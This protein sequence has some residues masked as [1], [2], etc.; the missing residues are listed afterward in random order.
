MIEEQPAVVEENL[1]NT[2]PE[3]SAKLAGLYYVSDEEPGF[4]RKRRGRGFT[5]IDPGGRCVNDP[6]LRARF[7]ALVIPPAWTDVWICAD[8]NGHIQVTGRDDQGRKQYIYHP[9][10]GE[11]RN[12][13]KF[14]RL[15]P[16]GEA[17]PAIRANV[18]EDLRKHSLSRQKVVA[19]VIRLL[20]E[21]LI[22]IGN[23]EYA[24]NNE[25]YGL[26]TLRDDHIQVSGSKII[27]V[28]K[29]KSG[30][31]HEVDL[32]SKRLAELVKQ[33]QELP[34]QELFQYLDEAGAYH[35]INSQD[36]NDYLR[37]ITGQDFTAKDFRTWGG[38]VLAAAEL[39]QQGPVE[40]E[41]ANKKVIVQAVKA[42]AE[43]LGNTP[44]ICRDYYIHPAIIDAYLNRSLFTAME[45]AAQEV[46]SNE[47]TYD[48]STEE[49]AVMI[50]SRQALAELA[51]LVRGKNNH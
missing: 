16:F 43:A 46:T 10:W 35:P 38:T 8:P 41:T 42:V 39:Y 22:R 20:E 47:A 26:T 50:L 9:R 7:E 24:R 14:H 12:L 1:L 29:G 40:S 32:K 5:Y 23:R 33:C 27:F 17:L 21:T 45:E 6:K 36:V 30:K 4:Q 31:Q 49:K 51:D 18:V 19:L 25:T 37:E 3:E 13:T 48:L 15:I 11:I 44:A 34:G 28:F 2:D